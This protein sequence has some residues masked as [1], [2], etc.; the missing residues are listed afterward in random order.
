MKK[1]FFIVFIFL[2]YINNAQTVIYETKLDKSLVNVD[3]YYLLDVNKILLT[4][5]YSMSRKKTLSKHFIID[6]DKN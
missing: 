1:L 3:T 6:S 2:G 4:E 5:N